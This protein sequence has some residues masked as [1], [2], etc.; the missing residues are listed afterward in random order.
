M[1]IN[2]VNQI[3]FGRAFTTKEKTAYKKLLSDCKKELGLKDTTA[4]TFDFNIPSEDGKNTAIGSTWSNSMHS[5]IP[6]LKDMMGVTSIQ[7]QPQGKI[8]RGN[9]SPYSGTSFAL[10]SHIIS[11]D[12]LTQ[13]EY[14]ALLSEE[15][16]KQI[17]ENYPKDKVTREYRTD[18]DYVIGK[19]GIQE[20]TLREA[21]DNFQKGL[22]ENKLEVLKLNKEF[23]K[24]KK[25]N[26]KWLKYESEF[27]LLSKHYGTENF[28]SWNIPDRFLNKG[29]MKESYYH[30]NRINELKSIYGDDFEYDAFVQFIA[31][32]QQ[33][34]THKFLDKQGVRV[35]G[36]CQI[37]FS[38]SEIWGNIDAFK[39]NQYYGCPDFNFEETNCMQA[40]GL[41]ALNYDKLVDYS[42][43]EKQLG[44]SGKL[45]LEKY[46]K[47]FERYDG[48]RIDAA[49]QYITPF[50][51]EEKNGEY[52]QIPTDKV[53][54]EI[55]FEILEKAQEEVSKKKDKNIMLE[56][57]GLGVEEGRRVTFNK[58]PH[59]YTTAYAEYDENP[60]AFLK[61]GYKPDMFY[62][63]VSSHDNETLIN[64]AKNEGK[65]KLHLADMKKNFPALQDSFIG[66]FNI[67][68]EYQS[69]FLA[70]KVEG[71]YRTVKM[72]EL[73][74]APN[75]FFTLPDMFGMSERINTS[76]VCNDDNW[77][78]RLPK[79]YEGFYHSQLIKGF[80]LN[81]PKTF[82]TA[83]IMANKQGKK[84][85]KLMNKCLEASRIL[86][87]DGPLTEVEANKAKE[88]GALK[89]TFEY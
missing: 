66:D 60:T 49:W 15:T 79:D 78:V 33:K 28:L 65:R 6:F 16:V 34:E 55:F 82:R 75:Q 81:I 62:I 22:M 10:G 26:A 38:K 70:K 13:K 74:T 7:V 58:F 72:A 30:Y 83:L 27:A 54:K 25:E 18:Y 21:F 40:W 14:G 20:K 53:D 59:I 41:S 69:E 24:F 8:S 11:L 23:Q 52:K 29:G 67:D 84:V 56:L 3:T 73:F 9:T 64:Q 2:S 1:K 48:V 85:Q 39:L 17:D 50:V 19:N 61:K 89:E 86:T 42:S 47:F 77:T 32:K 44:A 43:G 12:K 88:L 80:G 45:L 57:V 35:Y 68:R 5:F 46:K 31:D 37:G 63:G 4:I 51:Y 36:D 76:G 71:N 87:Q